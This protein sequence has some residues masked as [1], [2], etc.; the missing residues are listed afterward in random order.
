MSIVTDYIIC[1]S[2]LYG[3][4]H[5]EKVVEIYNMQNEDAI[6]LTQIEQIMNDEQEM[7]K[8]DFVYIDENYFIHETIMAF[9][10]FDLY[11]KQKAGKPYYIPNKKDLLKYKDQF[12]F[13]KTKEYQD[14]V[15]YVAKE[16]TE[17]DGR[18]ANTIV[19]DAQGL[20][21]VEASPRVILN[22]ITKR[23]DFKSK[24]QISEVMQLI[25]NLINNTR[26]WSNN[27][28]TPNELFDTH[29]QQNLRPLP[30][31]KVRK[32]GRNDPCPCGSGK[33]YKKC[34]L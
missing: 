21:H 26:I 2:R 28:F 31:D 27:G 13:E 16:F 9:D 20:C 11:M 24:K 7:L 17:G 8:K 6:T 10:E 29:E 14:F 4:V 30:D 23:I 12:Y 3:I 34:C 32:I 22:D 25:M 5:K 18:M 1:L 19:E 33:K 15:D